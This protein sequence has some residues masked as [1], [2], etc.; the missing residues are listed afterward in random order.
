MRNE[1][2]SSRF[3]V[4][5]LN[6]RSL[7]HKVWELQEY[8]AALE[9]KPRAICVNETFANAS[10]SDA[11]LA[12]QGYEMIARRDGKDTQGGKCRG[13]VIYVE[14]GL[15]AVRTHHIGEEDVIEATTVEISWGGGS[16]LTL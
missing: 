16:K 7:K 2:N 4:L 11:Q 15:G 6:A 13:L 1:E 8:I 9:T 3:S 5:F 12:V 14:E 10:V